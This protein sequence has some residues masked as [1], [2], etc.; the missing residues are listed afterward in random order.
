[1]G[2]SVG[3]LAGRGHSVS[4]DFQTVRNTQYLAL[5]Q[6]D[7]PLHLWNNENEIS[8]S[9]GKKTEREKRGKQEEEKCL[10]LRTVENY[11]RTSRPRAVLLLALL[12]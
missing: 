2:Y 7:L 5:A 4:C 6:K 1:M 8:Q 9:L 10:H 12:A 3:W 11:P